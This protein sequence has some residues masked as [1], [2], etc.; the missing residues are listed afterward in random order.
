MTS[1]A[2]SGI[3]FQKSTGVGGTL[4]SGI[5]YIGAPTRFFKVRFSICWNQIE[6]VPT[7]IRFRLEKNG[8]G[9]TIPGE[10]KSF[11]VAPFPEITNLIVGEGMVQ[12][13]TND[14]V[15][16]GIICPGGPGQQ[17]AITEHY[18]ILETLPF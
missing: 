1:Y 15:S 11:L 13:A 6:P 10:Y 8:V 7:E 3:A 16:T 9:P 14:V 2:E 18:M 4:Q 5:Q 17:M 12:L